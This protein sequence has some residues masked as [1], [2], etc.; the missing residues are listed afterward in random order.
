M[1]S[2][3]PVLKGIS[4]GRV[5][6]FDQA[7][8]SNGKTREDASPQ[9]QKVR[10]QQF[11]EALNLR[12]D[13]K[14][15]FEI[16]EHLSDDGFSGKNTK[17]PSYKKLWSHIG[18]GRI[19]FIVASELS[20]ISRNTFDFLE[21]MAHCD[22]HSVDVMIINQNFDTTS[23]FGRTMVTIL[24]TLAQFERE[25]TSTRVRENAKARLLNDGKI[26]GAAEVLGLDR[27]KNKKGHFAINPE[28]I[29]TLEKIFEIYLN[30]AS[31]AETF[32]ALKELNIK[33]KHGKDFTRQSFN[34]LFV[35]AKYRY[36]GVW[37]FIDEL[38][39]EQLVKLPHKNIL[40]E[41][42]LNQV[43][44]RLARQLERK[45]RAGKNHVYL[46]TTILEHEDGTKF[47][48]H[49]AKQRQYRYYYNKKNELRIRCDELDDLILKRLNDYLV[50]D[51]HF[52]G[53]IRKTNI[54]KNETLPKLR[55]RISELQK[56]L[57]S[58]EA[59]ENVIKGKLLVTDPIDQKIVMKFLE[60]H[61]SK[62]Y[63][64]KEHIQAELDTIQAAQAQFSAPVQIDLLKDSVKA[65]LGQFKKLPNQNKRGFLERL[66]QR[67]V[68][69]S[70]GEIELHIYEDVFK[71]HL[72]KNITTSSTCGKSGGTSRT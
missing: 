54:Q 57:K 26:N 9:M 49:P 56:E 60:E 62:I 15:T 4:Y 69:K 51:D 40:S 71:G 29:K 35:S 27:L 17:R 25:M 64:R 32:R 36:R 20:R 58:I 31:R 63:Q 59:E 46:L 21:L 48:G 37:P 44:E 53:L 14:G 39:H 43:E 61:I 66:F 16:V 8:H 2:K 28:E 55:S 22:K 12:T 11:I 42:L 68:I 19:K 52:A 23:P 38:G 65:F 10:C 30:S 13:R 3:Y 70:S 5:S 1:L 45:R 47:F 6:T 24:V 7:Y 67:I 72:G 41:D 18:S 34:Q 33:N 50:N